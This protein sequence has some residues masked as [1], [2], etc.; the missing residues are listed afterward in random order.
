MPSATKRLSA[1][2]LA[3]FMLGAGWGSPKT[4]ELIAG[5]DV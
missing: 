3:E 4:T 5:L 2:D 1:D